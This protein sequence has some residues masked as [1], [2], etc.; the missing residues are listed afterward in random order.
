MVTISDKGPPLTLCFPTLAMKCSCQTKAKEEEANF[1]F[2][3]Q[4]LILLSFYKLNFCR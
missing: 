3:F 2:V 1:D 4:T